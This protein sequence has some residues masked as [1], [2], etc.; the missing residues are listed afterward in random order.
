[1]ITNKDTLISKYNTLPNEDMENDILYLGWYGQGAEALRQ[2]ANAYA[3]SASVLFERF[4]EMKGHFA[5]LDYLGIN[6]VFSYRH[7]CELV[8][9]YL[10]VKY[11]DRVQH[12]S[13][14]E[15]Y[16]GN[17]EK[18]LSETQHSLS[19]LWGNV[20]PIL[21]QLKKQVRSEISIE[22]ISHYF[23]QMDEFDES[24]MKMRY[25]IKKDLTPMIE[26]QIKIDIVHFNERMK[27]LIDSINR[28]DE[29][30][31]NQISRWASKDKM[32]KCFQCIK[33]NEANFDSFVRIARDLDSCVHKLEKP[34]S[35]LL[36]VKRLPEEIDSR[37]K[38][39][40]LI[41]N[42]SVPAFRILEAMYY[43][44]QKQI[45]GSFRLPKKRDDA[46]LC[47]LTA[48][49]K[50]CGGI[51]CEIDTPFTDDSKETHNFYISKSPHCLA[52]SVSAVIEKLRPYFKCDTI[53]E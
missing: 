34:F 10:Y 11:V 43:V 51:N 13:S 16:K 48:I 7:Y 41:D 28:L 25:P 52:D 46:L 1:M 27:D 36:S 17:V 29:D 49:I 23:S 35:S 9:K 4:V 42:L 26:G 37:R 5:K 8:I 40:D 33:A 21:T 3:Y 2:F 50:E 22:A 19:R 14:F 15:E 20:K 53:L 30:I 24:S 47:I 31:D 39:Q 32:E 18:F 38:M 45:H 44:G 6:I 12:F